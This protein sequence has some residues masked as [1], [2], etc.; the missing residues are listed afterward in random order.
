VPADGRDWVEWHRPYDDPSTALARRLG[1]VTTAIGDWLD[2]RPQGPVAM[3][4]I[5]AGQ[6]RDLLG[7]LAGREDTRR[8]EAC[9][10][11]LDPGNAR[12]ARERGGEIDLGGFEVREADAGHLAAYEGLL[13]ADLLLACG[14]FGN[15]S[16]ADIRR[17]I[18]ALPT[19]CAPAATVIWTRTRR[20]PDLTPEIRR[21]F[22]AAGFEE[23]AF[24]APEDSHFAV[25][26]NRLTGVP[27]PS[28]SGDGRLFTFPA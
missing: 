26:V 18:A 10:V 15:I 12:L 25:G 19:L 2:G 20:D 11:E 17:T 21:R 1:I 6:G 3:T 14:V 23:L 4:S 8:I 28:P 16:P 5:C 13:P 24:H 22:D 27:V 9:L 7:A